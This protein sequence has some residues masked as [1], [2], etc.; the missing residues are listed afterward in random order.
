[1]LPEPTHAR[2]VV[3]ELRELDLQLSFGRHRVLREDVENQLRPVDD[4]RLERVLELTLLD[5]RELVVHEQR[6]RPCTAECLL[7]LDKLALADVRPRLWTSPVL[8]ELTDRLDPRCARQ[9][10]ELA[11]LAFGVYPLY[12]HGNDEPAFGLGTRRRI[13]LA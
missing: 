7:E 6:L 13:R 3:L 12:Q 1:V 11:K 2:Q 5:G 4:P 8:D 10:A 9:L